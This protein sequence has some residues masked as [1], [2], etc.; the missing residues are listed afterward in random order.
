MDNLSNHPLYRKHN[1]DSA[2]NSFWDFY[3]KQFL[4]L[5]LLSLCMSLLLQYATTLIDFKE[6][7]NITDPLALLE[8]LKGY[9]GP[10]LIITLISL[11]F[12]T[13]IHYYILS[14]P[15]DQSNNI[16][17]CIVKSLQYYIPYLIIMIFLAAAGSLAI[18]FG[19][20]IFIIGVIFSL[21][22]I[23]MISMF[24]LPVMMTE[25]IHIGSTITR[26]AILSHR[27]FWSNIGWV[28]V[29]LVLYLIIS[30]I[31]S[32]VILIPFSGNLLKTITNPQD[33]TNLTS[34]SANPV[35]IIL[36]S[37]VSALT[38]PIMPIFGFIL[39]FNGRAREEEMQIISPGNNDIDRVR[40]E[41][42][43]AKP[44]SDDQPENPE[45]DK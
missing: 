14:N 26:T 2:M 20:L 35:F 4:P 27:N 18:A 6:L 25:G 3:K 7:Q 24:I 29:F 30:I 45:T 36:S 40:V 5:F 44:Y 12:N 39:Y 16:L 19:L 37:A 17:I 21:I 10:I 9:A 13:I 28:S 41:D 38:M 11:L 33:A 1:I 34:L 32:G 42:L 31:L 23:F 15:L 43:Y 22:Y 8:K